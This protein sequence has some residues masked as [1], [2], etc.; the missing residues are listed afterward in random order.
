M[1]EHYD[2]H[3]SQQ[4]YGACWLISRKMKLK[5]DELSKLA[6]LSNNRRIRNG[7]HNLQKRPD[8]TS[9][10]SDRVKNGTHPLLGKGL[11][12]PKV[13]KTV[14]HFENKLTREKVSM[15]QYEF[16]RKYSLCQANI[17]RVIKGTQ[18]SYKKWIVVK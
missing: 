13:D 17:N 3:Y 15:T 6:S 14:Y 7:T 2:I 11:S 16:V 1:Q 4:D 5:V 8:G 12:H 9:V 10:S 18:N